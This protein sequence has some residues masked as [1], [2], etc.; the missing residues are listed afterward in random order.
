MATAAVADWRPQ[1]VAEHKIK[2]E[3]R[4]RPFAAI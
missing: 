2:K 1:D 3:G 4:V